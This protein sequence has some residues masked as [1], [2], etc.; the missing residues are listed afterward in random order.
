MK[1]VS[2]NIVKLKEYCMDSISTLTAQMSDRMV[3]MGSRRMVSINVL[4]DGCG[5]AHAGT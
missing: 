5:G 3:E 2:A 4:W 1:N